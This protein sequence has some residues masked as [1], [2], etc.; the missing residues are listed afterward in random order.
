[1]RFEAAATAGAPAAAEVKSVVPKQE[2]VLPTATPAAATL[3]LPADSGL[4]QLYTDLAQEHTTVS[5]PAEVHVP[6]LASTE[7]DDAAAQRTGIWVH[8][9]ITLQAVIAAVLAHLSK[10]MP[11]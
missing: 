8:G 11:C 10:H 3:A 6:T 5:L 7:A 2:G 4:A 9:V 1:V